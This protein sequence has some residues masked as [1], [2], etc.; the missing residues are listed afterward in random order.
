ML[1]IDDE[2]AI[3]VAEARHTP[4]E[5]DARTASP[6]LQN[7]SRAVA[8]VLANDPHDIDWEAMGKKTGLVMPLTIC[9]GHKQRVTGEHDM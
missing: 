9:C 7:D 2:V 6:L 3:A 4:V 1:S 8:H 5:T